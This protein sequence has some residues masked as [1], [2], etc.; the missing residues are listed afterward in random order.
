M[1][2]E[3]LTEEEMKRWSSPSFLT[4]LSKRSNIPKKPVV[5]AKGRSAPAKEVTTELK[6][7]VM[8]NRSAK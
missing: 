2:R 8:V 6:R 4:Y 3:D 5:A 7:K 1:V